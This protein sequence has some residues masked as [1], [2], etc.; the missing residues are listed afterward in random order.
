[1]DDDETWALLVEERKGSNG[2]WHVSLV[3]P[4]GDD[5]ARAREAGED[6]AFTHRP[7]LAGLRMRRDVYQ[8]GEDVWIVSHRAKL[9]GGPTY[10]KVS[11]VRHL[12]TAQD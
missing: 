9:G 12:G 4:A 8:V 11:V 3:M 10:F 1:M 2:E 7:Q 5:L 6:L